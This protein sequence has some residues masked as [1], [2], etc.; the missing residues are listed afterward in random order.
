VK[1]RHLQAAKAEEQSLLQQFHAG[2]AQ[3]KL[4]AE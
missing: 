2:P 1:M 3:V 4:A